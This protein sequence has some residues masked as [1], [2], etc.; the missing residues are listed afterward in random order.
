VVKDVFEAPLGPDDNKTATVDKSATPPKDDKKEGKKDKKDKKCKKRAKKDK[1]EDTDAPAQTP[2][3]AP[4]AE[5]VP[6]GILGPPP[7]AGEEGNTTDIIPPPPPN[8]TG[9]LPPD[10]EFVPWCEDPSIKVMGDCPNLKNDVLPKG[11]N[12]VDGLLEL[13][14]TST[15]PDLVKGIERVLKEDTSLSAIGCDIRRLQQDNETDT[16]VTVFVLA[17][18]IGDASQKSHSEYSQFNS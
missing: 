9:P 7:P 10:D 2:A 12:A 11:E 8:A 16:N 5:N 1:N 6:N 14:V 17:F 18:E 15:Q 3:E 13:E 4:S